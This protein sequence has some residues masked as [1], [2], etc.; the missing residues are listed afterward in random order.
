M[1][2]LKLNWSKLALLE[3]AFVNSIDPAQSG[4]YI[5]AAVRTEGDVTG[6]K[7]MKV[8]YGKFREEIDKYKLVHPGEP[9][10][11][12]S[13]GWASVSPEHQEKIPGILRFLRQGL[14]LTI[15]KHEQV[16]A[17]IPV[18]LPD[19]WSQLLTEGK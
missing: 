14:R 5:I 8:G 4:V 18:T 6:P 12:S 1:K 2:E 15:P 17:T 7:V 3:D 19:W 10:V 11:T 13:I 9:L 16:V